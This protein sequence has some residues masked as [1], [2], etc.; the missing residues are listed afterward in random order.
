MELS[1]VSNFNEI[2]VLTPQRLEE[3]LS[4]LVALREQRTVL[5]NLSNMDPQ[6]AQRTADF[7]S[8]GVNALHGQ[9]RRVGEQV[10]LFT[11]ASV[12][13]DQPSQDL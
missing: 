3:G 4:A 2:L 1:A 13:I 5:L 9:E 7:V 6:L 8:G 11:P 12:V 10:F